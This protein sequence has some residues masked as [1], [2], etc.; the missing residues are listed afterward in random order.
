MNLKETSRKTAEE[1]QK[2]NVE[3]L[4]S[5]KETLAMFKQVPREIAQRSL[6][7]M[8]FEGGTKEQSTGINHP[9]QHSG[10]C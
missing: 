7:A 1:F 6:I 8:I 4:F 9:T 2:I 5:R 3:M 10:S